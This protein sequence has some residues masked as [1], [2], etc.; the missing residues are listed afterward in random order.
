MWLLHRRPQL[1][2]ARSGV[3]AALFM[4]LYGALRFATDFYRAD[5]TYFGPFSSGQWA[6]LLVSAIGLWLLWKRATTK[7]KPM[8]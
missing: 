1:A 8:V 4:A 6:S 7:E 2:S 5:D 3:F